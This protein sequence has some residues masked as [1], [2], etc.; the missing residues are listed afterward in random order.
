MKTRSAVIT[1]AMLPLIALFLL[2]SLRPPAAVAATTET[3]VLYDGS[4]GTLPGAQGFDFLAFPVTPSQ[5]ISDG[6]V[7][8]DTAADLAVSAGYFGRPALMPTLDRSA[9]FTVTFRAAVLAET[10]SGEDRAGFSVVVLD[11][12]SG[13]TGAVQGIELGFWTGE[14]WAQE[15]DTQGGTLFTH[16]ERVPFATT[17]ATTYQLAVSGDTY[18]LYGGDA[19]LLGGR[20]RNYSSFSGFPDP[21]ET[22]NFLFLGDDTTSAG[23]RLKLDSVAIGTPG[24]A[25]DAFVYLPLVRRP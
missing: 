24:P 3:I 19:P 4:L 22:P 18:T 15:D 10:H 1:L 5:A 7:I 8:L 11:D 9:G 13:G 23:A 12:G 16:A 21:Y 17:A 25:L 20:V 14:I 6:G 2:F